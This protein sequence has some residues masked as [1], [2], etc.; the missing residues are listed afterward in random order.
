MSTNCRLFCCN[1]LSHLDK[2]A[3][4]FKIK[5]PTLSPCIVYRITYV[6]AISYIEYTVVSQSMNII[7]SVPNP[8]QNFVPLDSLVKILYKLRPILK[9]KIMA[10]SQT[11]NQWKFWGGVWELSIAKTLKGSRMKLNLN[12]Q[13]GGEGNHTK[14]P[15]A[16]YTRL[17]WVWVYIFWSNIISQLHNTY[18]K[19]RDNGVNKRQQSSFTW[20]NYVKII[21][22]PL[23]KQYSGNWKNKWLLLITVT[24]W[25]WYYAC[26]YI[27]TLSFQPYKYC[28]IL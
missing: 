19:K 1:S 18:L 25:Y 21:K 10:I 23:V 28:K 12:L 24:S 16:K 6:A 7:Y 26:L 5:L 9:K 17:M 20:E 27:F 22:R 2:L 3:S 14:K 13:R 8:S 15:P 11:E 4:A